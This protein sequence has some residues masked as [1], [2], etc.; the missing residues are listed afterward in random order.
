VTVVSSA[1]VVKVLPFFPTITV[2]A[3]ASSTIEAFT[4][5]ATP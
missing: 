4:P 3:Q 5:Q 2:H 1:R